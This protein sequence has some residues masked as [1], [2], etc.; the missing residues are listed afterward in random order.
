MGEQGELPLRPISGK[1]KEV[2][3]KQGAGKV[4]SVPFVFSFWYKICFPS[5][6]G[7][8]DKTVRLLVFVTDSKSGWKWLSGTVTSLR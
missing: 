5:F 2:N 6:L 4:K 8:S 7:F 1:G 3:T